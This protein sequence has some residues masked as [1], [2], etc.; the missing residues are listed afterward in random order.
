MIE[1]LV[2]NKDLFAIQYSMENPNKYPPLEE[3][4]IWLNS[5][6]MGGLEGETYLT[7]VS[8][9]LLSVCKI[10]DKIVLPEDF[11]DISDKKLFDA[12][13]TEKFDES[14][15]YWFMNTE[16]FDSFFSYVYK[17]NAQDNFFHF[18]WQINPGW[19]DGTFSNQ[20]F[21]ASVPIIYYTQ[22]VNEFS[23]EVEGFQ[24]HSAL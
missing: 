11:R 21:K 24:L 9:D 10:S 6:V 2:G 8:R 14:G 18:L 7:M 16:G 3:C 17:R 5:F 15:T 12:M 19:N 20:L 4:T 23:R 22:I 1:K 13:L